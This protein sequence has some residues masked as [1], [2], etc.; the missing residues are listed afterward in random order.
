MLSSKKGMVSEPLT[1][2]TSLH[3]IPNHHTSNSLI[4]LTSRGEF[5]SSLGNFS[6]IFERVTAMLIS[7]KTC[8]C[9][10]AAAG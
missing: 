6:T 5:H 4:S 7:S 1:L 3:A 8:Y 2:V 9:T 10:K